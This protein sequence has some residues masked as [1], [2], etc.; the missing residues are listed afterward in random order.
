MLPAGRV[1]RRSGQREAGGGAR[2]RRADA[3]AS[4]PPMT[5]FP[6][7][8]GPRR[9]QGPDPGAVTAAAGLLALAVFAALAVGAGAGAGP[10]RLDRA[11][12]D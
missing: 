7:A 8:P 4:L 12:T 3:P 2:A 5:R 11:V 6:P 1:R 10:S 9:A